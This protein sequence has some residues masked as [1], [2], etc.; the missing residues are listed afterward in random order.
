MARSRDATPEERK[1]ALGSRWALLLLVCVANSLASGTFLGWQGM[2]TMLTRT[3]VYADLCPHPVHGDTANPTARSVRGGSS[4]DYGAA[5]GVSEYAGSDLA[6]G[7]PVACDLQYARYDFLFVVSSSVASVSSLLLGGVLDRFGP[8][9]CVAVGLLV[10]GAGAGVL[11]VGSAS[12]TAP[13]P[14]GVVLI[15]LGGPGLQSG[16]MHL[17]SLFVGH[18]GLTVSVIAACFT[19]SYF[20]FMVGGTAV[21]DAANTPGAVATESLQAAY[22]TFFWSY[23]GTLVAL[24]AACWCWLP[25]HVFP[26]EERRTVVPDPGTSLSGDA[27]PDKVVADSPA[28]DGSTFGALSLRRQATHPLFVGVCIVGSLLSSILNSYNGTAQDQIEEKRSDGD[29]PVSHYMEL[30]QT[31]TALGGVLV[32]AYGLLLDVIAQYVSAAF[33]VACGIGFAACTL[34]PLEAQIATFVLWSVCS[35]CLFAFL[36][37]YVARRF[38]FSNYG[39]LIGIAN[40]AMGIVNLGNIPLT[41]VVIQRHIATHQQINQ[42]TVVLLSLLIAFP[43]ADHYLA[44]KRVSAVDRGMSL[45]GIGRSLSRRARGTF[46]SSPSSAQ[47]LLG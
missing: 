44:W 42:G 9:A 34:L 27:T 28:S 36:Y 5:V 35:A 39:V 19:L 3:G 30:F 11:A 25:R 38:G 1:R 21:D 46:G 32:P 16:M 22:R 43:V 45:S 33:I 29:P 20:V 26:R 13:F 24:A 8:H 10:V 31:I 47:P 40:A 14:V 7:D 12:F 41:S 17:S 37:N 6:S 15:G 2:V 4:A 18:E 23:C